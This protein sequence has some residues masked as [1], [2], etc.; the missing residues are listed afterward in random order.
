MEPNQRMNGDWGRYPELE[1]VAERASASAAI[2]GLLLAALI[3][4]PA[5]VN[6]LVCDLGQL[7]TREL[8]VKVDL[9]SALIWPHSTDQVPKRNG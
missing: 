3:V 5:T 1:E 8:L 7:R 6:L 9:V 4:M 2:S